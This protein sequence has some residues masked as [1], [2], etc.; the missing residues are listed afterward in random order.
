MRLSEFKRKNQE[1]NNIFG[2]ILGELP[3]LC[4][5][6]G[7]LTY[8]SEPLVDFW[9]PNP[10]CLGKVVERAR[11]LVDR[12]GV[13]CGIDLEEYFRKNSQWSHLE[14]FEGQVCSEFKDHREMSLVDYVEYAQ[15][16]DVG[17]REVI[18]VIFKGVKS[19]EDF[20]EILEAKGVDFLY[21]RFGIE[22]DSCM[23]DKIRVFQ[24][25]YSFLLYKKLLLESKKYVIIK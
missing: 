17:D 16:P 7:C 14:L 10:F 21:E 9:C 13:E 18:E 20:Y 12:F 22:E 11:G 19:I 5:H 6:C 24:M 1:L 3:E 2:G 23:A 25:Y 4:P 15:L 8:V